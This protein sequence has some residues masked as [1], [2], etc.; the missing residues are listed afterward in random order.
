MRFCR[1]IDANDN[2]PW[3][4]TQEIHYLRG[5]DCPVCFEDKLI[6]NGVLLRNLIHIV[7]NRS[8]TLKAQQ[9]L[10]ARKDDLSGL[11]SIRQKHEQVDSP[12]RNFLGHCQYW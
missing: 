6:R 12:S 11:G 7:N 9:G 5:C 3:S 2:A 10:A 1:A 4:I 8:K